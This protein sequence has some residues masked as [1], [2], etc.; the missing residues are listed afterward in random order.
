MKPIKV[1]LVDDHDIARMGLASILGTSKEMDVVG[2]AEDGETALRKL[3]RLKPDVV[4]CD[5]LMPGMDGV[6]TTRA[7]LEK[8][9]ETKVLILTTFG[10]SDGIAHA[11]EA[12]ASGALL[13]DAKLPELLGAVKAVAAGGR[14]L[15]AEIEQ[16]LSESPPVPELSNRQVEILAALSRGL[17]NDDIAKIFHISTPVARD[18]VSAL[19]A[20]LHVAN[21]AEAVA[22]GLRK[23]LLR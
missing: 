6:A 17:S 22:V 11:L 8:M 2:D 5:L 23:H 10:T 12:G 19:L 4:I 13:K 9:P 15:S 1:M 14:Y 16:I 3:S 21:R 18:L 7:I 20:K